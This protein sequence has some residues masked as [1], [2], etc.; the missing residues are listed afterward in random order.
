MMLGEREEERREEKMTSSTNG[1][2]LQSWEGFLEHLRKEPLEKVKKWS[3][4]RE[5]LQLWPPFLT[6]VPFL[7]MINLYVVQCSHLQYDFH[8]SAEN[9]T[10]SSKI[11]QLSIYC[12]HLTSLFHEQ[13]IIHT[14]CSL[15]LNLKPFFVGRFTYFYF[16]ISIFA[17][18]S[19]FWFN[20]RS[21]QCL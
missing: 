3:S 17:Q 9:A 18:S 13:M 4:W 14:S 21:F 12:Y 7:W 2:S 1:F 8:M 16:H 6:F 19:H 10:S 5:N 15:E 11:P 20:L